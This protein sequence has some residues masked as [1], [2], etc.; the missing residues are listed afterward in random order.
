MTSE[1][2]DWVPFSVADPEDW[3]LGGGGGGGGM[4]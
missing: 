4:T 3:T 2:Y 1:I